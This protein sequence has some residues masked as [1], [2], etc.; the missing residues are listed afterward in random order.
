MPNKSVL[1]TGASGGIGAV[2]A[3]VFVQNGFDVFA[4]ARNEHALNELS[5]KGLRGFFACDLTKDCNS[6]Y[7]KAKEADPD[8]S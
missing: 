2:I 3:D 6:L 5:K 8:V 4:T 7:N 1:I